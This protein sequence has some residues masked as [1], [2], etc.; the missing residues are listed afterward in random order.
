MTLPDFLIEAPYGE[1]RL[2]GHRIG[3]YHL[4]S[5]YREG[6]SPERLHQEY[7]TLPLDLIRKVLDFYR[8]NRAEVDAYVERYQEE[9]DHQRATT[10]RAL[11]WEDLRRRF[12]AMSREGK[13]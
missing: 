2:A 7:P 12:E 11:D 10:P 1:I 6:F 13:T 8:E 3:L 5:H 4:V 9:I